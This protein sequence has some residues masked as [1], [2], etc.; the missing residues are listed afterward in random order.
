[1]KIGAII[2][3][4]L[5]STRLP[6][7]ALRQVL[8]KP[9]LCYLVESVARC[10]EID[11]MIV[12]TS[13][14]PSDDALEELCRANGWPCRRGPLDDVALRFLQ[15]AKGAGFDAFVRLAGD[16][17]LLDRR[18]VERAVRLYKQEGP[19]LATNV[20]KR[21]FPKGQSVEVV[22]TETFAAAYPLMT[23]DEERE[24]V[25]LRFY[26]RA[27]EYRLVNFESGHDYGGIQLSVDTA[28]DMDRFARIAACLERPHWEYTYQD[29]LEILGRS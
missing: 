8:G 7:K 26:R 20:L 13:D 19:D 4:R 18:L 23:S 24:H 21:T 3:A 27:E 5:G 25:T 12:A 15:T 11:E 1:M 16:S 2:Q 9:M 17:P 28:E 22:K 14:H 6:G 29:F 10:S